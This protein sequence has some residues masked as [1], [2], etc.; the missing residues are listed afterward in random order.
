[1]IATANLRG[2]RESG[3]LFAA[4]TYLFVAS[5]FVLIVYGAAGA[6]FNFVPEAPYEPHPPG[7]EGVGLFLILRAFAS[8]CAALTGLE[9]VSDA[10]PAFKKPEANNARIVL[11]WLGVIL[12]TLFLGTTFLAYDL[13]IAPRAHETVVSQLA[14]RLVGTGAFYYEIQAVTMLILLLAAN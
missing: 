2:I 4:P 7:L 1:A 5:L 11:T 10:V 3:K 13:G 6:I 14:R 12:I 9:A 8:G